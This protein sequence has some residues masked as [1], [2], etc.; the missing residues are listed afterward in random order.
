[1][2]TTFAI[3]TALHNLKQHKLRTI[4]TVFAVLIGTTLVS[5][6]VSLGVGLQ[7]VV[8]GG[9]SGAGELTDINV[10]TPEGG[11]KLNAAAISS[12]EEIAGVT[13]VDPMVTL[14]ADEVSVS[15]FVKKG[16]R[17]LVTAVPTTSKDTFELIAGTIFPDTEQ[18]AAVAGE[19]FLKEFSEDV[20]E[21]FLGKS[22]I[23]YFGEKELALEIVG[24]AK[25]ENIWGYGVFI[26]LS[27]VSQIKKQVSYDSL[28]VKAKSVK[29]VAG[30][31]TK[32]QEMGFEAVTLKNL[33]GQV[34]KYFRI[35]E[36]LLGSF[37]IIII[38]VASLGII[39]TMVMAILERT[40]QIG[41]MRAV[42]ASRRDII[43][44]FSFEA[45]AIGFIGGV[46]GV[47]CGF[48]I[49]LGLGSL[50]NNYLAH[51]HIVAAKIDLFV[52]PWWLILGLVS[53]ATLVG[54]ISGLYPAFRAARLDPVDALRQE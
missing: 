20:P 51:Q 50:I 29:E 7:K 16:G 10:Y 21:S 44:I 4:L 27:Q 41:V 35:L 31:S 54:L 36:L 2:K 37:G 3:A 46:L 47:L 23:L 42:G 39:N 52:M 9:L 12:I 18:E 32:I 19:N 34:N 43:K 49:T 26:P 15:G 33:V 6:M 28:R 45:G 1:M 5:S 17:T 38:G 22:L 11:V 30:I 8:V 48:L 25:S 40:R 53:F 14:I 24:V 13:S